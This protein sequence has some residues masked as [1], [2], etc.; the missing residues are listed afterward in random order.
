[1]R[2]SIEVHFKIYISVPLHATHLFIWLIQASCY[3]RNI[4]LQLV[5]E[6]KI[7]RSL[8]ISGDKESSLQIPK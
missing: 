3:E 5:R 8:E 4:C 2:T 6:N 1:M 7:A